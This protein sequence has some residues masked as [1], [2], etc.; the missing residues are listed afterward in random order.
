MET[1]RV[2]ESHFFSFSGL[3]DVLGFVGGRWLAARHMPQWRA[4]SRVRLLRISAC[5]SSSTPSISARR[6]S[7]EGTGASARSCGGCSGGAAVAV[8]VVLCM[9][10]ALADSPALAGSAALAAL[11]ALAA[12]RARGRGGRARTGARLRLEACL[13]PGGSGCSSADRLRFGG[14]CCCCCCCCCWWSCPTFAGR[15]RLLRGCRR[16]GCRGAL[17]GGGIVGDASIAATAPVAT[18]GG[19]GWGDSLP[20]ST[21]AASLLTGTTASRGAGGCSTAGAGGAATGAAAGAP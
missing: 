18:A 17:A 19:W 12:D 21:A 14:G 5:T 6:A 10:S 1:G 3:A 9:L 20:G 2:T 4:Q 7:A 8:P 16:R 11:V 15:C 13:P